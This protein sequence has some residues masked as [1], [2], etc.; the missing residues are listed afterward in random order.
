MEMHLQA[1]ILLDNNAHD[2]TFWSTVCKHVHAKII[3]IQI[4]KISI[5]YQSV[6]KG[7]ITPD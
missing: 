4:T 2:C 1:F 3:N 5:Q 6:I 7:G